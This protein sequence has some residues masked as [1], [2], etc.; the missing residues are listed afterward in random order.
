MAMR[1]LLDKESRKGSLFGTHPGSVLVADGFDL[2]HA[3]MDDPSDAE[4]GSEIDR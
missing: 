1:S 4:T 3:D 2:V